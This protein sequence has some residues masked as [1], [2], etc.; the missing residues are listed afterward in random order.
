MM[1]TRLQE[2]CYDQILDGDSRGGH[3]NRDQS[4]EFRM[5]RPGNQAGNNGSRQ[6]KSDDQESK[7]EYIRLVKLEHPCFE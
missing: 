3:N 2:T 6:G 7:S 4:S 5:G 1:Q